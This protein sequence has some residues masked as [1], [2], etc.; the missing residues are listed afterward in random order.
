MFFSAHLS[1]NR[2]FQGRREAEGFVFLFRNTR[3][4][5]PP[6]KINSYLLGL[7]G[8]PRLVWEMCVENV[9][10]SDLGKLAVN[11]NVY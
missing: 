2:I 5:L 3:H 4:V 10:V 1:E 9:L 6:N 8:G 7:Y 11:A